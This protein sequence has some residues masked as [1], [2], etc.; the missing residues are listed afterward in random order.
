MGFFN[1][2]YFLAHHTSL[3]DQIDFLYKKQSLQ[4]Y[5][6]YFKQSVWY[7]LTAIIS[8]ILVFYLFYD[9]PKVLIAILFSFLAA[10][11]FPHVWVMKRMFGK[12]VSK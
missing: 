11:T 6:Q 1:L 12:N 7:W 5:V 4:A 10:L 2:F 9:E 8:L 3:F